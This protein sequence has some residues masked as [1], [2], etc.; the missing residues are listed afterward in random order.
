MCICRQFDIFFMVGVW[1]WVFSNSSLHFLDYY[2]GDRLMR[3]YG[4]GR[5]PSIFVGGVILE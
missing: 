3:N 1:F 5:I 4:V 2:F